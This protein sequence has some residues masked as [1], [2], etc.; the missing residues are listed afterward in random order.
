VI[1]GLTGSI[2]TGK[3]TVANLFK[4]VGAYVID[5]DVLAREV[6]RPH[7]KA[8]EGEDKPT[9]DTRYDAVNEWMASATLAGSDP[10]IAWNLQ[11]ESVQDNDS[12]S[13]ERH[14]Q[15]LENWERFTPGMR[16]YANAIIEHYSQSVERQRLK[17]TDNIFKQYRIHPLDKLLQAIGRTG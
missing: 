16:K 3:S 9:G 6:Q 2:G 13:E 17:V 11:S 14:G 7:L 10:R 5:W 12:A 15:L 8:W 1:I 4:E